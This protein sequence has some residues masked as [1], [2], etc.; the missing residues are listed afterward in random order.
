MNLELI[1]NRL[2][3]IKGEL[4]QAIRELKEAEYVYNK[5]FFYLLIHSAMGNIGA[6]EA[7]ANL[8]CDEE[9]L[10]KP[11]LDKKT[12]VRTLSHEKEILLEVAKSIRL[13]YGESGSQTN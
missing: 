9:G 10:W 12:D 1:N 11:F 3:E 13:L 5:R 4:A 2:L 7:E 8:V 6:R